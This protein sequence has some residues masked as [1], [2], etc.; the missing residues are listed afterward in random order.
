M[1]PGH[2]P[3]F[4]HPLEIGSEM[5][6]SDFPKIEQVGGSEFDVTFRYRPESPDPAIRAVYLAGSFNDWKET[7]HRMNGPDEAGYFI[8]T[9]RLTAGLYEY[10][11]V[12]EG[13]QWTHDPGNPDINGPFNNSVVRVR[14]TQSR[15]AD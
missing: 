10:K 1:W 3:A 6:R 13:N 14:P 8:T 7:G 12:V 4:A 15:S 9:L 5:K 2:S 11:F